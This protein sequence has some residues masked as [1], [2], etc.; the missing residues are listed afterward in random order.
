[1]KVKDLV[2]ELEDKDFFKKFANENESFFM[3]A[4]IV[5]D[6]KEKSEKIQLDYFIKD[7]NK[8]AAFEFPFEKY[9]IHDELVGVDKGKT[10]GKEITEQTKQSTELKI[11][12]DDLESKALEII[13]ENESDIRPTKIISI[14]KDN[15]W[16]LTCMNEVLGMVRIKL[17]AVTGELVDFSKGSLMDFMGIKKK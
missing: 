6:L 4:F 1:M 2:S 10:V 13:S 12:I 9:I 17:N 15:I 11:D 14:L 8:I 7:E 16:N 5:L 3:A